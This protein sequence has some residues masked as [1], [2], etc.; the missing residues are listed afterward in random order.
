VDRVEEGELGYEGIET[1]TLGKGT[2]FTVMFP[3]S[4][5]HA[6]GLDPDE[7]AP[8]RKKWPPAD[9]EARIRL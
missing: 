8:P 9:F 3:L 7:P 2:T 1:S 6:Q 5:P 4:G